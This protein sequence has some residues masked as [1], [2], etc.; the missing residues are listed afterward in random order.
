MVQVNRRDALRLGSI[1]AMLGGLTSATACSSNDAASG[2]T[3]T[4]GSSSP[5]RVLV[6]GAGMSGLTAAL[7]LH[8]RGHEVTVLEAQDRIGGR[9]IS[10][11]YENGQFTEGGGGHFRLNM[12][13]V[14]GYVST[15]KLP[16]VAMNDGAPEYLIDGLRGNNTQLGRRPWDLL[17]SERTVELSSMLTSYFVPL[18]ADF[19]T[20]ID[21]E[22]PDAAAADKFDGFTVRELLADAGASDDFAK[23]VAAQAGGFTLEVSVLGLLPDFAYHFGDRNLY[24]VQGG[25]ERIPRALAERLPQDRIHMGSRVVVIDQSGSDVEVTTADGREWTGDEVISTIP[26]TVLKDVDI[27]PALPDRARQVVDGMVWSDIV[28][29]Y[30][31]TSKPTW[32][33]SGVRGWPVA[34]SDRPWERLIDITGNE[35]G[36]RGN[37]FFYLSGANATAYLAQPKETRARD[38]V[39]TFNADMSGMIEDVVEIGEFSW[40]DQPWIKAAFGD[41]PLDGGWMLD[42]MKKP[43]DRLHW[44][45][46]F[47]TFKSGWVEGAIEA[48]LRAARHIDPMAPAEHEVV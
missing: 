36:G 22:W 23:L 4:D 27:R 3:G 8:R 20:V 9:L 37:A 13:L 18:G 24:R 17:E 7:A 2:A 42:E 1:A 38:L 14:T 5:K 47:T 44:A 6:L 25:N 40:P 21:P 16:I 32:L 46:D 29:V 48:G 11:E 43:V 15:L 39:N 35:P 34:A 41:T 31:Q 33:D 30:L 28:K 10:V 12:P 19:T 26:F 45:G